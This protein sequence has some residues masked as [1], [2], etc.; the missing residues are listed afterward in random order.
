M[1]TGQWRWFAIGLTCLVSFVAAET[2]LVAEPA[3]ELLV[4]LE[5]LRRKLNNPNV[6]ILDVR[7]EK[8]YREGHV[9]GAVRVDASEWRTLATADD[10]LLDARGWADKVGSLGIASDSQVVVY[11]GRLSNSARIWWL[12][13]YVG[14]ENASLLDGNWE[15]WIKAGNPIETAETK[16]A[17][18]QF[19]PDFQDDRLAQ[20]DALKE[21]LNQFKVIDTR[22][23]REFAAGRIPG[24]TQL[25][26]TELVAQDGRFKTRTQ[27]QQLFRDRGILP[28]ET[29]VCY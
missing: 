28:D 7:S 15:T 10:G 3:P 11:G 24:A 5:H 6:R 17:A 20:F 18:R 23:D 9:P 27:L 22:S 25:E 4:G 8:D 29:A 19:Q 2:Q 13:K 26:W 14:V 16:P 12:L 21:S 1:K